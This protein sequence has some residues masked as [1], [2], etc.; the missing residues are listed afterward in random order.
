VRS[1]DLA[2]LVGIELD[3]RSHEAEDRQARD[4]FVDRVFASASL[5]LLHVPVQKGYDLAELKAKLAG[6][7]GK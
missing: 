4:A 6:L 2:P 7:V 5:P 1:S 3:D